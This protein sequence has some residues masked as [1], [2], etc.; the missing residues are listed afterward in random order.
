[1]TKRRVASSLGPCGRN[2]IVTGKPGDTLVAS[3]IQLTMKS[4]GGFVV[5][6]GVPRL[7]K[8]LQPASGD[9]RKASW[10]ISLPA[11]QSFCTSKIV[12]KKKFTE[13]YSTRRKVLRK[14]KSF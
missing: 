4:P 5:L 13:K 6:A 11:L 8:M 7:C 14:E 2:K 9:W 10:E 3:G 12:P 1:M